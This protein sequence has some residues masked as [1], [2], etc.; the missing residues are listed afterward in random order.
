M[1]ISRKKIFAPSQATWPL[2]LGM[3]A[4]TSPFVYSQMLEEVIVTAERRVQSS[5]DVPLAVTTFSGDKIGPS[6]MS[7]I[8]DVAL[9]TPNLTVTEYNIAEPQLFLRGVG[10]TS[11]SAGSDPTV[12][13]FIDEVYIG[14]SGGSTS[15]LYDLDRIEVL[16]GPQ[17]TL[18][19]R[20]VTGG[21]ISIYSK[22][23]SEEFE[24]KV[25]VTVGDYDLT[26]LRAYVNGPLSDNLAGK[27][28]VSKSDRDGY[29]KNVTNG[30][31]LD[32]ADNFGAR[33]QLMWSASD[34]TEVLFSLDY[35]TDDT[36]GGCR[37]IINLD[38]NDQAAGGAFVDYIRQVV[39][40]N[41]VDDPRKCGQSIIQFAEKDV[42]G[43]SMKVDHD[44]GDVQLT[45]ITAYREAEYE[46]LQ[47]LA[48]LD[49]P[50]MTLSVRDNESE[51]SD[52]ISQEFRLSSSVNDSLFWVAGLYGI[53]ETVDRT[54]LVPIRFGGPFNTGVFLDRS[55]GQQAENTSYA[56]FGQLTWSIND[57]VDLTAGGR[58]TWD[59]KAMDQRYN[60]DPTTV[61]YDLKGLEED[62]SEFTPRVS[63]DWKISD[64]HMVYFTYSEGYKS[65]VFLSQSTA[66]VGASSTLDPEHATNYEIGAKTEWLDSRLRFNITYFDLE[67]TDLQLFRLEDFT[68]VTE[69]ASIESSG[70]EI[71][72]VAAVTESLTLSGM[73]SYLDAEFV[74]GEFDGN[75]VARS[76]ENKYSFTALY[77]VQMGDGSA[78]DFSVTGAYSDELYMEPTNTDISLTDDYL[79]WDASGRFTSADGNWDLEL[80]GKNLSDEL[81]LAHSIDASVGG[82]VALYTPPR[83]YGAT[84]NYYWR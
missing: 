75:R 24:S 78:L 51:Q 18:Y 41:N 2:V 12:S 19:G 23:P 6:G 26:V 42:F 25:G 13:M 17:G 84:F 53:R 31:D 80:W 22:K 56:I 44:F 67:I 83:T 5:Q 55:W 61:E 15:D 10:S 81:I 54:A 30:Q 68:L 52:Q 4:L 58:Q 71:D 43:G 40:D 33:G 64:A 28:T 48:G 8:S 66:E 46:W 29:A 16:R 35:S 47:E 62:W 77:Q 9:Q 1:K 45:S 39:V 21:A 79:T 32:N 69:N 3:S 11:D 70:V 65:G 14:R 7:G 49:S 73:Y 27:V 74:G 57:S 60:S 50:P 59:T 37:D 36:N 34:A 82:T 76:P 38:R 63:L 72:F 20:N